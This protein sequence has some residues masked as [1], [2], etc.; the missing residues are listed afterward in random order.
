MIAKAGFRWV[1]MDF[2]WEA[3]E[4]QRAVY[5][6]S[7]YDRLMAELDRH[8]I[9]AIFIFDYGNSLYTKDK[10]VRSEEARQAFARWSV[11]AAKHFAGR[12]IV[13]ELFNE[14]NNEMFWPPRA[15]VDEYVALALAVGRAFRAE[16]PNEKLIGPGASYIDL[17]FLESCFKAGLLEY[18][19]AVSVHP[20]RQDDP[21]TVAG[22]YCRLRE[23]IKS[24]AKNREVPIVSSEW[25]Y[26]TLWRNMSES[27]QAE[28]LSRQLLTNAANGI[29]ISIWYDWWDDGAD[30][31][32]AEHHFGIVRHDARANA[33]EPYETKP[34]FQ[35][36]QA[37]NTFLDG[38]TFEKRL[39]VGEPHDFVLV[40]S[41]AGE[42]RVAAWTTSS[43]AK[44]LT[45]PLNGRFNLTN[46]AG[47]NLGA[48][49]ASAGVVSINVS[50][51]PVYLSP[52][53]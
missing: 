16:V 30:A 4:K 2:V 49:S 7:A 40:F 46:N 43:R 3:T 38:A 11:A 26:S 23:L 21:E 9:K 29:P 48:L 47:E 36:A 17:P 1:R 6:F 28:M 35:A 42:V 27:K 13:W 25:G 15:N 10:A 39:P 31:D 37:V 20:Y 53:D 44:Q 41:R 14:P 5:D 34:A 51:A 24:Y 22:D 8:K 45:I 19:S 50:R 12:G 33:Q 52:Q 18:W 32:A